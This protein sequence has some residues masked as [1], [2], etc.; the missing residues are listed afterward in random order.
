MTFAARKSVA[1][2]QPA[3]GNRRPIAPIA[4]EGAKRRAAIAGDAET[5]APQTA[6]LRTGQMTSS[7]QKARHALDGASAL[8]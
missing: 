4:S 8:E 6:I 5:S 3:N 2:K 7:P 1:R